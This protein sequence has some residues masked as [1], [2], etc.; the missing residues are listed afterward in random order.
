LEKEKKKR[1]TAE[2]QRPRE[3]EKEETKEALDGDY[4][5]FRITWIEKQIEADTICFFNPLNPLI[6][7]ERFFFF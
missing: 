2:P 6:P 7:L 5:D 4:M 3:L 1:T